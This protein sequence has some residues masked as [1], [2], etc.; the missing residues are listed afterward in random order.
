MVLYE[1]VH[2]MYVCT[3]TQA[4]HTSSALVEQRNGNARGNSSKE[5]SRTNISLSHLI[6]IIDI[7]ESYTYT[8][9]QHLLSPPA[10]VVRT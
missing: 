7:L 3:Y 1:P 10:V 8:P 9:I 4:L 2:F 6:Y 5:K